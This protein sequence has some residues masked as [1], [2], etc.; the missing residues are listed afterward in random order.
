MGMWH[1]SNLS[2]LIWGLMHAVFLLVYRINQKIFPNRLFKNKIVRLMSL[3]LTLYAVMIAWIPFRANDVY[4]TY[5]L[6]LS[7]ISYE[8]F[9]NLGLREDTYLIAFIITIGYFLYYFVVNSF[10][11]KNIN[12]KF[13]LI[14]FK[15]MMVFIYLQAKDQF[16]YFQF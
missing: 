4:H 13:I 12:L 1:G 5:E 2:F 8:N 15:V 7:L 6:F 16:I 10:K 14:L 9:L 11:V 3:G